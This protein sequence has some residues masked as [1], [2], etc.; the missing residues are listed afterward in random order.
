MLRAG[1]R[2]PV[3][4]FRFNPAAMPPVVQLLPRNSEHLGADYEETID[5][6]RIGPK[7]PNAAYWGT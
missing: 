2:H 3:A 6:Y 7:T 4:D 5:I 1:E